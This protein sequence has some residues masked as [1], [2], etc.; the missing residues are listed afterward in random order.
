MSKRSSHCLPS[1]REVTNFHIQ[2][3][4]SFGKTSMSFHFVKLGQIFK[5][6]CHKYNR[7]SIILEMGISCRESVLWALCSL[8]SY[9][10]YHSCTWYAPNAEGM[11]QYCA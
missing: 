5:K 1:Q 7:N 4:A 2:V 10:F 11:E 6:K 8:D 9:N 3:L